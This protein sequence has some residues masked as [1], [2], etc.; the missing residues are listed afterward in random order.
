MPL[1]FFMSRSRRAA[2]SPPPAPRA[3]V[4]RFAAITI[5]AAALAGGCGTNTTGPK[6][7]GATI[8]AEVH[9][10]QSDDDNAGKPSPPP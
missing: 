10:W 5:A 4:R 7:V 9:A 1:V 2:S 3:A 6:Q 8:N